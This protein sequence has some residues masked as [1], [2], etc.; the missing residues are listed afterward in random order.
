MADDD[1][2]LLAENLTDA[3]D[4][5]QLRADAQRLFELSH[6]AVV[7]GRLER[8]KGSSRLAAAALVVVV[9]LK[10]LPK[11]I[12]TR[13]RSCIGNSRPAVEDQNRAAFAMRLKVQA[14]IRRHLPPKAAALFGRRERMSQVL[15]GTHRANSVHRLT[16]RP[17]QRDDSDPSKRD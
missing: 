15:L 12:E 11:G 3:L 8:V 1:H 16:H 6:I 13:P 5:R 4:V 17:N 9:K 14:N 10:P 7:V 2:L